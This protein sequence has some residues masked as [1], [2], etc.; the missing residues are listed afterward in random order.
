MHRINYLIL[1]EN[2][3]KGASRKYEYFASRQWG[4]LLWYIVKTIKTNPCDAKC[5]GSFKNLTK[6]WRSAN[7][8][9][10]DRLIHTFWTLPKTNDFMT[11]FKSFERSVEKLMRT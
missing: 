2:I 4:I 9:P 3:D 6:E 8:P 1:N 11:S 5:K 10:R 7:P